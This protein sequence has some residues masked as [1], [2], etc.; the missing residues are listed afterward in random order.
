M[1]RIERFDRIRRLGVALSV[2]LGTSIPCAAQEI[3]FVDLTQTAVRMELRHPAPRNGE[4]SVR[5]GG[6]REIHDCFDS[7]AY[8]GGLRTTLVWLD[9]SVYS[10][11]DQDKFEV[12]IENIGSAAIKIPFSPHLADLQPGDT[13]QIRLFGSNR[14]V[15]DRGR[16]MGNECRW[17]RH[18]V[19]S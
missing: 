3:G 9:R 10:V 18:S 15:M 12:G 8:A 11:D 5:K 4:E 2:T 7:P 19:C 13:S 6:T 1:Q 16:E 14:P 17:K